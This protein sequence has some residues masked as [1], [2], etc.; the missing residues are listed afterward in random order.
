MVIKTFIYLY[1]FFL[2]LFLFLILSSS[3]FLALHSFSHCLIIT[4]LP[5][6]S[7]LFT[8]SLHYTLKE[9][10]S[11]YGVSVHHRHPSLRWVMVLSVVRKAF[12][13]LNILV[14]RCLNV[15]AAATLYSK[16]GQHHTFESR[17]MVL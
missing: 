3:L 14:Q 17:L 2:P 12:R 1:I 6:F 5:S 16:L 15:R 13:Q 9:E 10:E 7:P 11:Q 8:P 4:F